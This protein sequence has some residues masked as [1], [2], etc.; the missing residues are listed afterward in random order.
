MVAVNDGMIKTPSSH[1]PSLH[2]TKKLDFNET[3]ACHTI[4]KYNTTIILLYFSL[5]CRQRRFKIRVP[6]LFWYF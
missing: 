4:A 3:T 2:P 6:V 1:A 5:F